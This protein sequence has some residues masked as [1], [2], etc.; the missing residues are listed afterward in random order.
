MKEVLRKQL[1]ILILTGLCL[2]N[3]AQFYNGHQ[4]SFGKNRVQYNEFV[5]SFYRFEKYDVYFNEDGKNLA[6]YTAEYA[7]QVIPRIEAFFDYTMEKRLLFVVY[8][9]LTDYRQSNIGLI[10]GQD[11]YNIGGTTEVRQNKAF[12]YFEGD[13]N[14]FDEQIT[15]AIT[16]VIINELLLGSQILDNVTNSTLFSVPKWYNEGLVAYLSKQWD[17]ETENHV[18]D[19]IITGKFEKFNRLTGNDAIYAGHSFWKYISYTY[20]E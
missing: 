10:T 19:G 9:R 2:V 13:Y 3:H 12:L 15:A 17:L 7:E 20:G 18:K 11:E 5:W 8:N 14:K 16:R 4:M 1:I 6:D